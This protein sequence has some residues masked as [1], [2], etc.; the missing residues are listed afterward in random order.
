MLF[1][2][3]TFSYTKHVPPV[4]TI[5]THFI[6][7]KKIYIGKDNKSF[8]SVI[9]TAWQQAKHS[10]TLHPQIITRGFFSVCIVYKQMRLPLATR[11]MPR[12]WSVSWLKVE[13][14]C[15]HIN[16]LMRLFFFSKFLTDESESNI[17]TVTRHNKTHNYKIKPRKINKNIKRLEQNILFFPFFTLERSETA[18]QRMWM[19]IQNTPP[20]P[21]I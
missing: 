17:N 12:V 9:T 14:I 4:I 18:L 1:Y 19:M 11:C 6:I 16:I 2:S 13:E 15:C 10:S 21:Q 8:L 5:V 20:P 3:V 7:I